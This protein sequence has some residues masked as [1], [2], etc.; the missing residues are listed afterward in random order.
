MV[1][2][3]KEHPQ[4]EDLSEETMPTPKPVGRRKNEKRTETVSCSIC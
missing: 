3:E 1:D 2:D 4:Q